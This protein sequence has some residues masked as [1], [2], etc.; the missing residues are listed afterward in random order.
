MQALSIQDQQDVA[1]GVSWGQV[2]V[3]LGMFSLAVSVAA[4]G[5][6]SLI[7][8]GIIAGAGVGADFAIAGL[9]LGLSVGSGAMIGFGMQS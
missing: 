4:T 5:G 7:P 1:G 6:L 2:A 8:I 3:G 9:T